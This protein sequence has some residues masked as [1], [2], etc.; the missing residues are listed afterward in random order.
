[1]ENEFQTIVN[2]AFLLVAIYVVIYFLGYKQSGKSLICLD[3]SSKT[4]LFI[5]LGLGTLLRLILGVSYLGHPTDMTCWSGWALGMAHYGPGNFYESMSFADYPPGYLL[6]LWP[7]GAL[8]SITNLPYTHMLHT[9]LLKLPIIC[10]DIITTL[11]IYK[12]AKKQ[13]IQNPTL[14]ASLFFFNPAVLFTSSIWGQV[15]IVLSFFVILMLISLY[16]KQLVYAS[17]AFVLGLLIKP[18]MLLFGPVFALGYYYYCRQKSAKLI[19][20]QTSIATLAACGVLILICFPFLVTKKD[21]LWL[22]KLYFSTMGS[23]PYGSLNA[24][25]L[26]ALL[27]GLWASDT[28]TFLGIS[29]KLMGILGI[30]FAIGYTTF[31]AIAKGTKKHLA[32]YGALMI[33][34]IFTLGHHMHERYL[35]PALVCLILAYLYEEDHRLL[36]FFVYF[37]ILQTLTM[38]LVLKQMYLYSTEVMPFI[39]SSLQVLGYILFCIYSYRITSSKKPSKKR[40]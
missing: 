5:F 14:L 22:I 13:A 7:I 3:Y 6:I 26:I 28:A 30:L 24:P 36:H 35:F 9:L 33:L 25:N 11:L 16:N 1:M 32:L 38:S 29:Y 27:N 8:L 4:Q 17:I 2:L 21:P 19:L 34:G 37:S 39:L 20:K 18:Q 12:L 23:Y 15:D 31:L 10:F 40:A